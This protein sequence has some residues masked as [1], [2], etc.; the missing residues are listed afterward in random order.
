ML[1]TSGT[2]DSWF[3]SSDLTTHSHSEE[4]RQQFILE[5]AA[6]LRFKESATNSPLNV[7]GLDTTTQH[8]V[9]HRLLNASGVEKA[10]RIFRSVARRTAQSLQRSSVS[11]PNVSPTSVSS[12]AIEKSLVSLTSNEFLIIDENIPDVSRDAGS[13]RIVEIMKILVALGFDVKFRTFQPESSSKLE[14]ELLALGV[15]LL[16]HMISIEQQLQ[17]HREALCAVLVSRP[18]PMWCWEPIIRRVVPT[19]PLIYDTVDLHFMRAQS[20]LDAGLG[21][22]HDADVERFHVIE[23]A[24]ALAADATVVVTESEGDVLHGLVPDLTTFTIPTIHR[25]R[26][27]TAT[28]SGRAGM[29]FV[30]NF[31]HTPNIDAVHWFVN[32]I[33]PLVLEQLPEANLRVVGANMPLEIQSLDRPGL[34]IVGFVDE[35]GPIYETA[36]VAI[37]PL[38]IGAGIKGKVGESAALGVPVVG[39]T[40]AFDGFTFRDHVECRIANDPESFAQAIVELLTQDDSWSTISRA[41]ATAAS[42]QCDPGIVKATICSLLSSLNV[43]IP[44]ATN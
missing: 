40:L 13:V 17:D 34:D 26:N 22:V 30:G 3:G 19:I 25:S 5:R 36:R 16:D 28:V 24:M 35:V 14:R 7:D 41:A 29:L 44:A 11:P 6:T 23:T 32:E 15:E 8:V 31:W 27:D 21:D 39:T 38:R 33:L 1:S 9:S 18:E 42:A 2:I 37:A 12:S 43:R 10:D 20:A 4:S